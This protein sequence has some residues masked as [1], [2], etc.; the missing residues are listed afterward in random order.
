MNRRTLLKSAAAAGLAAGLYKPTASASVPEHNWDKYDWGW[1]PPGP[2]RLYHGPFPQYGACAVVPES[3]VSMVTTPSKEIVPNYGMGLIVYISDDTGLP[4]VPG[5]TEDQA[6]EDLIKLPF[7]Q[8]IYIRPNWRDIQK[9]P[10]R[11][12]F[13]AWWRTAFSLAR[14][15]DKQIGFRIMLENPD[16]PDPGMPDLLLDKVHS[17]KLKAE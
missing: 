4:Q 14:R 7:A 1:N 9:R 6:L 5:Q 12:D 17:V 8:K 11:L 10:G 13:P 15:Y 16:V 2:D 3:D